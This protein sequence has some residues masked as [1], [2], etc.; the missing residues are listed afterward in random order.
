M[1][2]K[3]L[4]N[5][6]GGVALLLWGLHMVQSGVIRAFGADLRRF[7]SRVLRNRISAFFAGIGVT[8]VL[9]SSTAV[10]MM[11]AS[12]SAFGLIPL[13]PAIAV[14][15]GANVGTTL[16]VQL[17]S[18]DTSAFAPV[19]L[20]IGVLAFKRST[21]TLVKD[22]GR[23]FIGLGLM[24]L[25]L[26]MLLDGFAPAEHA[27][28]MKELL[29]SVT[30]EP[31]LT[32]LIG[33]VIT[34]AAHSSV[35]TVLLSM[36]LASS[37]FIS[38]A[39]LF[40]LV[41]GANLGSALNPLLE[42]VSKGNPAESRLPA[43]NLFTRIAG[44]VIFLPLIEPCISFLSMLDPD[45]VRLAADFHTFFNVM[46]AA[47]FI[48]P[49]NGFAKLTERLLPEKKV[50]ADP[51]APLYLDEASLSMPS[52]A[53]ACAARETLRI[54]DIVE[55][56]LKN[57]IK[58]LF[59]NDRKLAAEVCR[60]DN[61]VDSLHEAVKLYA[62]RITGGALEDGESRRA[63][64]IMTFSVNLEHIG[65]IIDKNLMELVQKKIKH[66][67]RFSEEGASELNE[68]YRMVAESL[69]LSFGV[70]LNG[71]VRSAEKLLEEKIKVKELEISA[72]EN[73]MRR[74]REGR[75]E[76]IET[77]SLH[78]DVLRDLRRI[79]SHICAAAYPALEAAGRPFKQ[80]HQEDATV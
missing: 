53:L 57:G 24:L 46:T 37:G 48:I 75:Q 35:A 39:A 9:Q 55:S 67:L 19:F 34:W 20:V 42:G 61:I 64:E 52:V 2:I 54:G 50:S 70:F 4:L 58:A 59:S 43:A 40:A 33:A 41:L 28:L 77:S 15:L 49:L 13:A 72:S 7:L 65:D 12:F 26:H 10:A 27:P 32:L 31:V 71:D 14:M 8:A 47:F 45:S 80:A 21:R 3:V 79:H 6:T 44:C 78:L 30:D 23:V 29:H 60:T 1:G 74:L 11:L 18:F 17:L 5:L 66:H 56:M 22:L 63:F 76:S 68:L 36:S 73:H 16:I 38:G 62:V 25:S 69:R 51:H